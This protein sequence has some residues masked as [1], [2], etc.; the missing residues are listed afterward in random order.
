V[1]LPAHSSCPDNLLADTPP[2]PAPAGL[3]RVLFPNGDLWLWREE[4]GTAEPLTSGGNMAAYQLRP[5]NRAVVFLQ[6]GD[7]WLWREESGPA[8]RLTESS[9]LDHFLLSS[10]GALIAFSRTLAGEQYELWAINSDGSQARRLATASAAETRARY[11]DAYASY[12]DNN[13]DVLFNYRWLGDSH[14]LTYGFAPIVDLI[15]GLPPLPHLLV[16]AATGLALPV[17]PAVTYSSYHV[18]P[19]GAQIVALT[20]GSAELHLMNVADGQVQLALPLPE[21]MVWTFSPGGRYLIASAEDGAVMVDTADLSQRRL[22]VPYRNFPYPYGKGAVTVAPVDFWLDETTWHTAIPAGD[23]ATFTL[24]QVNLAEGATTAGNTFS[25]FLGS[26]LLSPDRRYLIVPDAAEAVL[27]D[28]ADASQQPLSFTYRGMDVGFGAIALPPAF[29]VDETT[30][31]LLLPDSDDFGNFVSPFTL[32]RIN[33]AAE[34]A[35]AINAFPGHAFGVV[36]S[37]D[38]RFLAFMEEAGPNLHLVDLTTGQDV[39]YESGCQ[40]PIPLDP[41]IGPG[42]W[43]D[44]R[45]YIIVKDGGASQDGQ[46]GTL[47]WQSLEGESALIGEFLVPPPGYGPY[48]HFYFK[49]P[50]GS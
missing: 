39:V 21:M 16:D 38:Y 31:Y 50:S 19:N 40:P 26:A 24:W 28:M 45:R 49:E 5:D 8:T 18:S 22:P 3:L 13:V 44:E 35:T 42:Q 11:P 4:T 46:Q 43:V 30:W 29:W 27:V 10:D 20:S 9:D 34:T 36:F 15:G 41:P 37:S 12:L 33:A 47:Y 6:A 2:L 7:L 48:F 17:S 23:G 14:I 25:G 1:A 32:W